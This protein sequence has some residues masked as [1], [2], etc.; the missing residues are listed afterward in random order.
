MVAGALLGNPI[1]LS[2]TP[3]DPSRGEPPGLGEHTEAV[4]AEAG[5]A[6][7]EIAAL[8]ASGAAK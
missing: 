2:S 5:Y 8:R 3:A 1:R 4:L 6:A 7:E